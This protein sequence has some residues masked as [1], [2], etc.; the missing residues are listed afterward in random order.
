MRGPGFSPWVGKIPWRRKRQPTPVLLP[1]KSHGQRSL[2]GCSPW[3]RKESDT[4]ERLH[5]K[6]HFKRFDAL[7]ATES[8]RQEQAAAD[9]LGS[10]RASS[11]LPARLAC[12]LEGRTAGNARPDRVPPRHS[13]VPPCSSRL[14]GPLVINYLPH[15]HPRL[16]ERS[17][18]VKFIPCL[19][20]Y[21]ACGSTPHM[22][23]KQTKSCVHTKS[24]LSWPTLCDP[25]DYNS[26]G[27]SVHGIL[28]A[29]ILERVAMPPS[30][31]SSRPRDWTHISFAY[32][33]G[34]WDFLSLAPPEGIFSIRVFSK[35]H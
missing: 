33:I 28:Q 16:T 2:V 29:R 15:V 8:E 34:R 30:T 24:L 7:G 3:G 32:C 35:K 20:R 9:A 11:H 18:V 13:A 1:G 12:A 4:T 25:M 5:F 17:T 14:I 22:L 23:N 19:G 10:R 26:P 31:G 6:L 21:F 27:S